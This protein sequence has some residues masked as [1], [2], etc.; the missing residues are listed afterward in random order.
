MQSISKK[1]PMHSLKNILAISI[2]MLIGCNE[3]N[4]ADNVR[5]NKTEHPES[6]QENNQIDSLYPISFYQFDAIWDV[7]NS[8]ESTFNDIKPMLDKVIDSV[9]SYDY[10]GALSDA[11]TY[12]EVS[13][14]S[15]FSSDE[16]MSD[17]DRKKSLIE[18]DSLT[19]NAYNNLFNWLDDLYSS[20]VKYA[21]VQQTPMVYFY[22]F[23]ENGSLIVHSKFMG[24]DHDIYSWSESKDTLSLIMGDEQI[25]KFIR[26][27]DSFV[28]YG[29]K[30]RS[31]Y[32]MD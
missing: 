29:F 16:N 3:K 6:Q 13:L 8:D 23:L 11:I 19:I 12:R 18:A 1:L 22:H 7:F 15:K 30:G 10:F 14:F 24:Y 26:E 20:P 21:C 28:P 25:K 31:L 5:Q 17:D 9:P 27:D 32:L 4:T 2:L